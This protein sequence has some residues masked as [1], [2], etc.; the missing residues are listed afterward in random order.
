MGPGESFLFGS[1]SQTNAV[2]KRLKRCNPRNPT[3]SQIGACGFIAKD[4]GMMCRKEAAIST[5][6]AKH[7]KYV[8][9][10]CPQPANRRIV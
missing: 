3:S 9:F 7:M 2:R 6:A 8:V 10:R 5:P 4:L 1:R